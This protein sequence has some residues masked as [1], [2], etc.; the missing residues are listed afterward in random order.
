[1]SATIKQTV[2]VRCGGVIEVHSSELRE[3]DRAEVTVVVTQPASGGHDAAGSGRW[4]RHAGAANGRDARAGDNQRIDAD[5]S[6]EYGS[7]SNAE[8]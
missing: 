8:A 7:R 2:T 6:A 5:L 1:M 4:R 3:G